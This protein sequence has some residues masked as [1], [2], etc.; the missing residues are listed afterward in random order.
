[1]IGTCAGTTHAIKMAIS[2]YP[3]QKNAV[4]LRD[5]SHLVWRLVDHLRMEYADINGFAHHTEQI[6]DREGHVDVRRSSGLAPAGRFS[7][8]DMNH[9]SIHQTHAFERYLAEVADR[10]LR[11]ISDD[12]VV[13]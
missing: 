2:G 11:R 10:F 8:K 13:R 5:S 9:S 6:S 7:L 1:M 12:S 4:S 3:D